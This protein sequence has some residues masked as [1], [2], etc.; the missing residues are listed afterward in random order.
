VAAAA[1]GGAHTGSALLDRATF[2]HALGAA[3]HAQGAAPDVDLLIRTGGEQRLSDFLLWECAYAELHFTRCAWP[4]FDAAALEDA[5]REYAQRER[6]YGGLESVRGRAA[7]A[8][9]TP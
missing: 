9:A 7:A 2:A 5:L 1:Q 4:D 8:A 3:M 6:R